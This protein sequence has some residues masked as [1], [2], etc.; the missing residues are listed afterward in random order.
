MRLQKA[1]LCGLYAVLELASHPQAQISAGEIAAKYDVSLNH[2]AKVLRDL[3]RA[4][5]IESVRGPGGGY[6]FAGN[7]RRVTL[8]DVIELFEGAPPRREDSPPD[9]SPEERALRRV[10]A[11]IDDMETA[12]LRS[13]SITSL[14]RIVEAE[15][16]K[17]GRG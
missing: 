6:R 10:L 1:T 11:D 8:L 16:K 7:P 12:T 13:A 3:V 14:V 15:R 2:L 9:E 4:G 17:T 5:L